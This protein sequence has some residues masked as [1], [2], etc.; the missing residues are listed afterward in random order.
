M[1]VIKRNASEIKNATLQITGIGY[2]IL[3]SG[4]ESAGKM[5]TL[6][7]LSDKISNN[8]DMI[9]QSVSRL[10]QQLKAK[11]QQNELL[12]KELQKQKRKAAEAIAEVDILQDNC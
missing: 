6:S 12:H 8:A 5:K 9:L 11:N 7:D 1:D 3:T 4:K 2:K 10:E